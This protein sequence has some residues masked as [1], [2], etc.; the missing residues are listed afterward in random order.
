[1][2]PLQRLP[3]PQRPGE[4]AASAGPAAASMPATPGRHTREARAGC[5]LRW[6]KRSLAGSDDILPIC[7]TLAWLYWVGKPAAHRLRR[8]GGS[9]FENGYGTL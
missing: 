5:R 4:P 9:M 7:K 3:R 6:P 2:V 1:M 8:P